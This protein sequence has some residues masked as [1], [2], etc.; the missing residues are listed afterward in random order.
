MDVTKIIT[1]CSKLQKE[2]TIFEN[3]N[4]GVKAK[5]KIIFLRDTE[6]IDWKAIFKQTNKKFLFLNLSLNNNE[7]TINFILLMYI[8]N[9]HVFTFDKSFKRFLR[10]LLKKSFKRFLRISLNENIGT[11]FINN[12]PELCQNPWNTEKMVQ[13]VEILNCVILNLF[14]GW[15]NDC[16]IEKTLRCI[17]KMQSLAKKKLTKNC[18]TQNENQIFSTKIA[19]NIHH[20]HRKTQ[21]QNEVSSGILQIILRSSNYAFC[22]CDLCRPESFW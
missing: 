22:N 19:E 1:S 3:K 21:S 14:N 2:P 9:K 16:I 13:L 10:T 18:A 15:Y 12:E 8:K 17:R 5:Y 6:I 20:L 7:E 11:F 4:I